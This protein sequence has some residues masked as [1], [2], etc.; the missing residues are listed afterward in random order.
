MFEG[1]N[2]EMNRSEINR[3]LCFRC[4]CLESQKYEINSCIDHELMYNNREIHKHQKDGV[5]LLQIY[6]T[7]GY[8]KL[9]T[10]LH[11]LFSYHQ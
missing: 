6:S 10:Y 11:H 3:E 4:Q 1:V 2:S 8:I 9:H 5:Y 7:T